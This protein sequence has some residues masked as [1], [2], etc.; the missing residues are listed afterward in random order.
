MLDVL[1]AALILMV[2]IV[3]PIGIVT[4]GILAGSVTRNW[5]R[6]QRER[7]ELQRQ[8]L[9]NRIELQRYSADMPPWL[10]Q[11]DPLEVASWRAALRETYAVAARRGGLN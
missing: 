2:V 6:L 10:D 3:M 1:G 11:N 8:A 7:L 5:F 9:A 4:F